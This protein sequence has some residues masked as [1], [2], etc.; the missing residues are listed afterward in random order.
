MAE[1]CDGIIE[2]LKGIG[3]EKIYAIKT[4]HDLLLQDDAASQMVAD[5]L[6]KIDPSSVLI[7]A[8]P[9]GR[10]LFSRV[11][12][13]LNCGLTADCTELLVGAK[14]DGTYYIKQNKPSYG[15]N[16][17]VTIIT[18]E[19]YY[20]QMMT[21]RPGV[22]MVPE[23]TEGQA[24]VIYMDDIQAPVSQVE[25]VEIL[26]QEESTDS[27][28]S[29]EIVVVGGRGALEDD[30]FTLVKEFADKI[31]AAIGGTRPMVDTGTI[32]FDH[33]IGQTGLTIRPK[34]C[35]SLGV[36]GAIQHT[37]VLRIRSFLWQSTPMKTRRSSK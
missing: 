32:P 4:D 25:V 9:T 29:S 33:Q 2:E 31:G 21:V 35:I 10:S 11:A 24:E 8:T 3:V 19:G 22:Y 36:S 5:M 15:E 37:E 30:N 27:I 17:F 14:E 12:V 28:L 20:P 1:S 18:R 6:K 26:P 13:K 34:I 7:P 23:Q 16:V